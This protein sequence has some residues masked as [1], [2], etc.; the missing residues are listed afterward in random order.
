MLILVLGILSLSAG[1]DKEE[2]ERK[3]ERDR[4]KQVR[5]EYREKRKVFQDREQETRRSQ[6]ALQEQKRKDER[7]GKV[8]TEEETSTFQEQDANYTAEIDRC[9][10]ETNRLYDEEK[11]KTDPDYPKRFSDLHRRRQEFMP[12]HPL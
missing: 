11:V 9:K 1:R 2:E 6:R 10:A 4:V 8:Y 3:K 7:A 5:D 12:R